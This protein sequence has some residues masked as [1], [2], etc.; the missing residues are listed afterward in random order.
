MAH[1]DIWLQLSCERPR[2]SARTNDRPRSAETGR[3]RNPAQTCSCITELRKQP[4][5]VREQK[6]MIGG[7]MSSLQLREPNEESLDSSKEVTRTKV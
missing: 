1:D 5:L 3:D 6:M 4:A 2:E 7:G